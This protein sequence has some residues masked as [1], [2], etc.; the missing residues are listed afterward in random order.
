VNLEKQDGPEAACAVLFD[1]HVTFGFSSAAQV[2]AQDVVFTTESSEGSFYIG[3]E[4][5]HFEL[6][7]I[8]RENLTH[9]LAATATAFA[10][11]LTAKQIGE[12][13]HS[14]QVPPGSI[15]PVRN[16]CGIPLFV[17]EARTE[18]TLELALRSLREL[19]RG[20]ILLALGAPEK[21]SR[22][23]RFGM[24]RIA[25]KY[26]QHIILTSDNPGRESVEQICS[27]LAQGIE[28]G[29]TSD[30][31]FQPDRAEAIAELIGMA[32]QGDALLISGKG[33]RAYQELANTIVP[34]DDRT[35]AAE[36][37]ATIALQRARAPR[38]TL[39]PA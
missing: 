36:R 33:D 5:L 8:G 18:R 27:V 12:A 31:H 9:L 37:L 1:A 20:R 23:E 13:L 7:L 21:T 25:A 22:K 15:E 10:S 2:S 6:P 30:Y 26:A 32:Q 3:N 16:S 28:S 34:F 19:T 29:G 17:D 39:V 14:L 38:R 24:G 35:V 11:D 4:N